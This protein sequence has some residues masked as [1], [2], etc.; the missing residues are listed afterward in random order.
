M[1]LFPLLSS[2][3]PKASLFTLQYKQRNM[4]NVRT[5][6]LEQAAASHSWSEFVTLAL[7]I[8]LCVCGSVCICV[9][10]C[11]CVIQLQLVPCTLGHIGAVCRMIKTRVM[12]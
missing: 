7:I 4:I 11:E 2:Y 12:L 9:C 5:W 6:K 8:V 10:V 3:R 1:C